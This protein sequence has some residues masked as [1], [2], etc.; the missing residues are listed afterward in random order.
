VAQ[1]AH[2][3][4]PAVLSNADQY[5]RQAERAY[6]DEKYDEAL[7]WYKAAAEAGHP[8]A[9][10]S[11]GFMYFS[12]RGVERNFDEAGKWYRSAL[13]GL[14]VSA[15]EGNIRAMRTL[16]FMYQNG[17]GVPVSIDAAVGQFTQA[18]NS[19]DTESM[20]TL[21]MLHET[22]LAGRVNMTEAM[23]WL[24]RAAEAGDAVAMRTLAT[25]YETGVDGMDADRT[26]AIHWYQTAAD[27]GDTLAT[28]ELRRL[29]VTV[30]PVLSLYPASGDKVYKMIHVNGARVDRGCFHSMDRC[31]AL[32][33]VA[34]FRALPIQERQEIARIPGHSVCS[35]LNA[36]WVILR[37]ALHKEYNV[38]QFHDATLLD[39]SSLRELA[40]PR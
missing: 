34:R 8:E 19:G 24:T 25:R 15:S 2:A 18:A 37:D 4:S 6:F 40:S 23:K 17:L 20:R 3:V 26:K 14:R 33:A 11:I 28:G 13:D 39:A 12:G 30:R 36:R 29:R 16:G 22:G 31:L 35:R 27:F 1:V 32:K 38:C 10:T 9:R 7:R 5:Y 21:S